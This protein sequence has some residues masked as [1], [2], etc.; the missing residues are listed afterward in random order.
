MLPDEEMPTGSWLDS[1]QLQQG[2]EPTAASTAHLNE[3]QLETAHATEKDA[4][5]RA[6]AATAETLISAACRATK[7]CLRPRASGRRR[8]PQTRSRTCSW[9]ASRTLRHRAGRSSRSVS[10]AAAQDR[11]TCGPVFLDPAAAHADLDPMEHGVLLFTSVFA[12]ACVRHRPSPSRT[13]C[14]K[15]PSRWFT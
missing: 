8:G 5:S 15:P 4:L 9:C 11:A 13:S 6:I 1:E 7:R 12:T 2:S 10:D 3:S 14:G